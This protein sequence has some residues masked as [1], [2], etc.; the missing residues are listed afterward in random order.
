MPVERTS[1]PPPQEQQQQHVP[2]P[3]YFQILDLEADPNAQSLVHIFKEQI[4]LAE[5]IV[6]SRNHLVEAEEALGKVEQARKEYAQERKR[7]ERKLDEKTRQALKKEKKQNEKAARKRGFVTG[8]AVTVTSANVLTFVE[9]QASLATVQDPKDVCRVIETIKSDSIIRNETTFQLLCGLAFRQVA[10]AREHLTSLEQRSKQLDIQAE[11]NHNTLMDTVRKRYKVL[12]VKLHPDKLAHPTEH[13]YQRFRDLQTAYQVL[14]DKELRRRYIQMM[15]HAAFLATLPK[16]SKNADQEGVKPIIK[17]DHTRENYTY[18]QPTRTGDGHRRLTGGYPHQC[19]MPRVADSIVVDGKRGHSRLLLAWNCASADDLQISRYELQIKQSVPPDDTD[20]DAYDQE[21]FTLYVG[22][23]KEYWTQILDPGHYSFR[24]RAENRLGCG[25]WSTFLDWYIEDVRAV[26]IYNRQQLREMKQEKRHRRKQRLLDKVE[27]VMMMRGV[28]NQ[29]RLERMKALKDDMDKWGFVEEVERVEDLLRELEE[30]VRRVEEGGEWRRRLGELIRGVLNGRTAER[31]TGKGTEP[32]GDEHTRVDDQGTTRESIDHNDKPATP[33]AESNPESV[34]HSEFEEFLLTLPT[35]YPASTPSYL[36]AS[37]RNQILQ[38]VQSL[39]R[40]RPVLRVRRM[41]TS[42][43]SGAPTCTI[44]NWDKT[45]R[46]LS[47]LAAAVSVR[48]YLGGREGWREVETGVSV[49]EEDLKNIEREKQKAAQCERRKSLDM[50]SS[51]T[52]YEGDLGGE[53]DA[54]SVDDSIGDRSDDSTETENEVDSQSE[55]EGTEGELRDQ[56]VEGGTSQPRPVISQSSPTPAMET[57][58]SARPRSGATPDAEARKRGAR[59]GTRRSNKPIEPLPKAAAVPVAGP[60]SSLRRKSSLANTN[61]NAARADGSISSSTPSL[62]LPHQSQSSNDTSEI[63]APGIAKP[64]RPVRKKSVVTFGQIE[65]RNCTPVE[66]E[67]ESSESGDQAVTKPDET[68]IKPR[69][70]SN[71]SAASAA[72]PVP[73]YRSWLNDDESSQSNGLNELLVRLGL[74]SYHDRFIEED[75]TLPTIPLLKEE[76]LAVLGI[77]K[78]GPRKRLL[79]YIEARRREGE[80]DPEVN[81][82]KEFLE[83]VGVDASF[84][85]ELGITGLDRVVGVTEGQLRHKGLKLGGLRRWECGAC[86]VNRRRDTQGGYSFD[87]GDKRTDR[88]GGSGRN[89]KHTRNQLERGPKTEG[90]SFDVNI[91]CGKVPPLAIPSTI[92]AGGERASLSPGYMFENRLDTPPGLAVNIPGPGSPHRLTPT[93]AQPADVEGQSI[94]YPTQLQPP[95]HPLPMLPTEPPLLTHTP[96][97]GLFSYSHSTPN[98][99]TPGPGQPGPETVPDPYSSFAYRV[100]TPYPFG[101]SMSMPSLEWGTGWES[102]IRPNSEGSLAGVGEVEM[103]GRETYMRRPHAGVYRSV[104]LSGMGGPVADT[105]APMTT[106]TTSLN[107]NGLA[108]AMTTQS[109]QQQQLY[110]EDTNVPTTDAY[111]HAQSGQHRQRYSSMTGLHLGGG[112]TP[113][114][115]ST[116]TSNTIRRGSLPHIPLT[117]PRT[118]SSMNLGHLEALWETEAPPQKQDALLPSKSS[119]PSSLLPNQRI[120]ATSM[121]HIGVGRKSVSMQNLGWGGVSGWMGDVDGIWR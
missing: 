76:D 42:D 116:T 23:M 19:T 10:D 67:S 3:E 31:W 37:T 77:T 79:T 32:G 24:V 87:V 16:P 82:V 81:D 64:S 61:R 71:N 17:R 1:D 94:H 4:S 102:G 53:K 68:D 95:L 113:I 36:D 2:L 5:Q 73:G 109:Q 58:A 47:V 63:G 78:I 44:D 11:S 54:K 8:G 62:R 60:S 84:G 45:V 18:V 41:Y 90:Y 26:R 7:D 48:S 72:T 74:E 101:Y 121:P 89:K 56:P 75:I 86:A 52:L 59:G 15:D 85:E 120:P 99:M 25:D 27:W 38:S 80:A 51:Q 104:S 115:I 40:S 69:M 103:Q 13:D 30:K 91:S 49:L 39:Y 34:G 22:A 108:F 14:M 88:G 92:P 46:I 66:S 28:S 29:E 35:R 110:P 107:D 100:P 57:V 98:L 96:P 97:P 83:W 9:A 114:P 118:S 106:S 33:V 93:Q 20:V 119:Q 65:V 105:Q 12:A 21:W 6:T 50:G 43:A 112:Y 70:S 117:H 111:T 55:S